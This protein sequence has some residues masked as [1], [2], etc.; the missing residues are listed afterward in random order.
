MLKE[1]AK[2][3]SRPDRILAE[4][5]GLAN[6]GIDA[7]AIKVATSE[8]EQVE[9]QQR[10]LTRLYVSGAMPEMSWPRKAPG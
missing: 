3:L 6:Q 7:A 1:V 4:A 8:L 2:V 9:E 10:R 5:K